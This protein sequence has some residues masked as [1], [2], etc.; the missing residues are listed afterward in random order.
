[1]ISIVKKIANKFRTQEIANPYEH[2]SYAQTGEDNIVDFI[3]K[4]ILQLP[5]F[6]YFDIG[7]HHP[8][9]LSNTAIFYQRGNKGL[10]IE[11]DPQLYTAIKK[12]RPNETVLNIGVDFS[13]DDDSKKMLDFYI[14]TTPT[15]NTFS[16]KEAK[17]L[18][19]E[20]QYK[21]KEVAKIEVVH[22]HQLFR[23][24]F[25]PDFLSIDVEGIDFE[26]VKS[27]DI[28]KYRPKVICIE[29]A[30]FDPVPPGKKEYDA[31]NYLVENSYMQFADTF[32][33]TIFIDKLYL[34]SIYKK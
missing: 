21:I 1:M 23:N 30:E 22:L 25:L 8:Y 12:A 3:F 32:N 24:Y 16:E 27:I 14:M 26:I 19:I 6:T 18:D 28:K 5:N 2:Q 10:S 17:R 11:P 31:I 34:N 20:G 29:T 7:A 9:Y 4:H 13:T 33:N 15:L